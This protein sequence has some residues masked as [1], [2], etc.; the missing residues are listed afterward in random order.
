MGP[1]IFITGE[2]AEA[3]YPVVKDLRQHS[4]AAGDFD[5]HGRA[6]RVTRAP[7]PLIHH[8]LTACERPRRNVSHLAAR[9]PYR[10][11]NPG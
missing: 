10:V 4:R 7:K 9:A 8:T 5:V 11:S 1:V 6:H 2:S 3:K